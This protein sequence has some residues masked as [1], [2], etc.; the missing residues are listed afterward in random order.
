[1]TLTEALDLQP[2][3]DRLIAAA[4][5]G[6]CV[7]DKPEDRLYHAEDQTWWKR[8]GNSLINADPPPGWQKTGA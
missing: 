6:A 1:M 8:A 2:K 5:F 7:L 3:M 4:V